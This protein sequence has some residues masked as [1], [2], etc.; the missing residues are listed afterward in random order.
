MESKFMV[1][2]I[3]GRGGYQPI[4]DTGSELIAEPDLQLLNK[5][6]GKAAIKVV[7]DVSN[8]EKQMESGWIKTA[9]AIILLTAFVLMLIHPVGVFVAASLI[10]LVIGY[11]VYKA[12]RT[13]FAQKEIERIHEEA[14]LLRLAE[15]IEERQQEAERGGPVVQHGR[16][17]RHAEGVERPPAYAPG[18]GRRADPDNNDLSVFDL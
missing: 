2:R 18:T 4:V 10:G 5:E 11:E 1:G 14:S 7:R 15:T 16:P 12:G 6:G 9:K 3:Q 13:F 17:R 8:I